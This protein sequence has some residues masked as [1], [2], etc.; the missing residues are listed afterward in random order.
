LLIVLKILLFVNFVAAISFLFLFQKYGIKKLSGFQRV[1]GKKIAE[2]ITTIAPLKN[3]KE[4]EIQNLRTIIKEQPNEKSSVI[5]VI[6]SEGEKYY[7]A[8]KKLS[9]EYPQF[10]IILSGSPGLHSG[11]AHNMYAGLLNAKTEI[12]VFMDADVEARKHN[13]EDLYSALLSEETAG[14]FSPAFYSGDNAF[15]MAKLVTNYF[16]THLLMSLPPSFKF[17]F[18]A[19]SFMMFKKSAI[20]KAGGFEKILNNISDDAS[21]GKLLTSAGFSITYGNNAV[22]MANDTGNMYLDVKQVIKWIVIIRKFLGWKYFLIPF[23]F[24]TGNAL[25]LTCLLSFYQVEILNLILLIFVIVIRLYTTI[26]QD[27][28]LKIYHN[29]MFDYLLILIL[30]FFQPFAWLFSFLFNSVDWGGRVYKI[31]KGGKIIS[32]NEKA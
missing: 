9:G 14:A 32:V 10:K 17:N 24:Y 6:E 7:P 21:L 27:F 28:I 3:V 4:S 1:S 23:T 11:K 19:G 22:M 5:A 31:G 18:C 20:E 15:K 29:K 16:F 2:P 13:Y 25:I 12:V 8:L 26:V 30:S